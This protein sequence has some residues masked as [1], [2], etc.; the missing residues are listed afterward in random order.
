MRKYKLLIVDDEVEVRKGIINK[1]EWESIGFRIVAEAENGREAL[2]LFEKHVPDVL[3]TDIKMPF[4]DGLELSKHVRDKYPTTKIVVMTGFDE[5]EYAHRAI[6]LNVTEYLLRPVSSIELTEI[7]VKIKKQIDKEMAEKENVEALRENYRKSLPILKEKFLS[8]LVKTSLPKEEIEE[9]SLS[10]NIDL[11]GTNFAA[12]VM[13]INKDTLDKSDDKEFLKFA[14]LNVAEEIVNKYNL[15][16][17]FIDN[18]NVVAIA[19]CKETDRNSTISLILR[20]LEELRQTIEKFFKF[21][22]TIGVGSLCDDISRIS[23]SYENAITALEYRIFLGGNRVIWIED[24]EPKSVNKIVFDENKER[25]LESIIKLGTTEEIS[26]CIDNL[27]RDIIILKGS[28]KDYQVYIMEML[29]TI[30]K[31]A[32]NSNVDIDNIFGPNYN[33]YVEIYNLKVIEEVQAWFKNVAIKIAEFIAKNRQDTYES[34]VDRAKQ[35]VKENYGDSE[36]N[37]N[38]LCNYIHISPTYFSFIFKKETKTTFI[39]YLTQVRMEAAKELL[40]T[41][42]MKTLEIAERVGYSEPNYFSYSFKK[43]FGISPSEYR[44]NKGTEA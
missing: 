35:Y 11:S 7:L 32:R 12:A 19:A 44:N 1:I 3:L 42:N 17:V 34:L 29:T 40:R 8:T 21:R 2:E 38:V 9:K 6:K 20:A 15:G 36:I 10:Y 41:T 43:K 24:I 28:I 39:N 18:E 14:V 23:Q 25:S 4:M 31:A 26:N 27:F 22:V 30:L 37:I 5:F 16:V 13:S 33:L